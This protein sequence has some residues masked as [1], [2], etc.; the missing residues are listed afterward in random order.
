MKK[1]CGCSKT[2]DDTEP[3]TTLTFTLASTAAVRPPPSWADITMAMTE[4]ALPW[5]ERER[6]ITPEVGGHKCVIVPR[7]VSS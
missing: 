5:S 2:G 1:Y 6:E 7:E 3:P 4:L